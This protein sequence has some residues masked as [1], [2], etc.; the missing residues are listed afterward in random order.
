MSAS[1]WVSK[2]DPE[3]TEL[4]SALTAPGEKEKGEEGTRI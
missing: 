3:G 1:V 2:R 4:S